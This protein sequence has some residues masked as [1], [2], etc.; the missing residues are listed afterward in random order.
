MQISIRLVSIRAHLPVTKIPLPSL[1]K[2]RNLN[3]VF[4]VLFN[5]KKKNV[6]L[7]FK[8]FISTNYGIEIPAGRFQ[9][10]IIPFWYWFGCKSEIVVARKKQPSGIMYY[11]I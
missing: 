9:D 7:V 6:L 1:S 5:T 3:F 8:A 10:H 2:N 11:A 4:L